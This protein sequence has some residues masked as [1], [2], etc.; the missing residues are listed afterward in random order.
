MKVLYADQIIADG[1]LFDE[2]FQV[3]E[4]ARKEAKGGKPYLSLMLGDCTGAVDAKLWDIPSDFTGCKAGDF[5]KV[6]AVAGIYR[7]AVQLK[8]VRLR[9]L[10]RAEVTIEDFIPASKRD[11]D[12]M[13]ADLESWVYTI[14]Q[15][16]LQDTLLNMIQNPAHGI[17]DRLRD[18]PAARKIHQ[19]YLGGLLEHTLNLCGLVD[20]VCK[21]YPDLDR[22]VLM[23]GMIMHD[24]GKLDELSYS[25]S[26]GVTRRGALLG[27]I[28]QGEIMWS[29]HCELLDEA[30]RDHVAH[31]IASHHGIREW[32]AA[33]LPATREAQV[34]H[35]IDMIDSRLAISA[36]ALA[37][38]PVDADGFTPKV[39]A[40]D[41]ALWNWGRE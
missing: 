40:L 6:R 3:R 19:A 29:Q 22:D 34:A 15:Q 12:V 10:E 24:L 1:G 32:G 5:V 38:Q 13:L 28:I 17:R 2:S 39:Y 14:K 37:S 41:T 9:V 16:R 36:E 23:A 33:V 18:A 11:R 31:I 26:I 7:D 4:V 20:A 8:L 27:H 21:V 30:T 25:E 35:L